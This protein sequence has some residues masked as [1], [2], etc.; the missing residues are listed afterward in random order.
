LARRPT[1]W[2]PTDDLTVRHSLVRRWRACR[3]V[4][5]T[6]IHALGRSRGRAI[7]SYQHTALAR[8][9]IENEVD[10]YVALPGQALAYKS[11]QLE[12]VR[13]RHE[14]E[15]ALGEAFDVREFH[16]VVLGRG[17]VGLGTLRRNVGSWIEAAAAADRPPR[18][19]AGAGAA[20]AP[21]TQAE[22]RSAPTAAPRGAR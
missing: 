5:D 21:A 16:D 1:R 8:N 4:V 13:L 20:I 10:R 14:A 7:S 11:G 18:P 17:A 12:I 9:N 6:G 3:L 15:A 19:R 2:A 22:G